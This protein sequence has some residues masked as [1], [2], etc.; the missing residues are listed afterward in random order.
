[1]DRSPSRLPEDNA[2]LEEIL[3]DE[4]ALDSDSADDDLELEDPHAADVLAAKHDRELAK[5]PN[6]VLSL[7]V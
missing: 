6:Y 7:E 2:F 3:L 1:M 5:N 4:N